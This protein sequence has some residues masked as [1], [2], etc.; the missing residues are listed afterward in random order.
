MRPCGNIKTQGC[1]FVFIFV[2]IFL[3]CFYQITIAQINT[4]LHPNFIKTNRNSVIIV[5][6]RA[7]ITAYEP[8]T[9]KV[10][11]MLKEGLITLTK[12]SDAKSALLKL[13]STNDVIGIKVFSTPG[14]YSGTRPA[15]VDALITIMIESGFSK[16]NIIVWD[17][18]LNSLIESDYSK[19]A[20]KHGI[21]LCG[22]VEY[23]FDDNV[24]YE[25]PLIGNLVFGDHEFGKKGE[26]IGRKSYMSKLLTQRITKIISIA[27]V[28]NHNVAMV[29]GHLYSLA[30]GSVD[31]TTR[32]ELSRDKINE[33]IPEIFAMPQIYDRTVLYITD[34]LICQYEGG[35]A[36]MLHYSAILGQ[37][38]FSFDPVVLDTLAMEEIHYRKAAMNQKSKRPDYELFQN[39][40]L[41]ELG[42]WETR[43]T[44]IQIID[45]N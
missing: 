13:L 45:L 12:S 22:A 40:S 8:D 30:L 28:I 5:R 29:S 27:P 7:A 4:N 31:N 15:V 21:L 42:N 39:A 38:W 23:G 3:T 2:L 26:G 24:F 43:K 11:R 36:S 32:F 6:N 44:N 18:N 33:A 9:E 20:A 1:C 16:S 14:R 41:L 19:I 10:I 25:K 35:P 17:K 37:L 34:A